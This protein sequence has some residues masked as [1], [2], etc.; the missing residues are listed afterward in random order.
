MK[1]RVLAVLL[2][3][4]LAVSMLGMTACGSKEESSGTIEKNEEPAE[5]PAEEPEESGP[6]AADYLAKIPQDS[7]DE[8]KKTVSE[9]GME[10]EVLTE[11]NTFIYAYTYQDEVDEAQTV[12]GLDLQRSVLGSSMKGIMEDM[13]SMG[14]KD[15]IVRY[16][17]YTQ[18]GDLI[19]SADF[20]EAELT[21]EEV[22]D[23][24][25]GEVDDDT[26]MTMEE[27]VNSETMQAQAATVNEQLKEEGLLFEVK[28]EGNKMLNCYTFTDVTKDQVDLE[29]L[30]KSFE[31][32]EAEYQGQADTLLS[33][34]V[35]M[36]I[37]EPSVAFL[38]L[39]ANGE[40][41]WRYDTAE[42]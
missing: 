33:L 10:M 5:E 21:A 25:A 28:A 26:A 38:F 27:F 32:Q 20:T 42:H 24:E 1:K 30:V 3:L 35:Q 9:M 41:L 13:I 12:A 40:E 15:P 17:Y 7:I 29:A 22:A 4:A 8:L 36:G 2:S 23:A 16:E 11:G 18:D 6:T 37:K 19:W 31:E 34:L 39:D 14:I